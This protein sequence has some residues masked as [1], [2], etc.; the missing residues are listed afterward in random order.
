MWLKM[1]EAVKSRE[2]EAIPPT[3]MSS[4]Y[5]FKEYIQHII[6]VGKAI[7]LIYTISKYDGILALKDFMESFVDEEFEVK[8]DKKEAE[9]FIATILAEDFEN[10]AVRIA[11][12]STANPALETMLAKHVV[13]EKLSY[14]LEK[15]LSINVNKLKLNIEGKARALNV[16]KYII[17]SCNAILK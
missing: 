17:A 14:T 10:L 3:S 11:A 13:S 1:Y 5:V 6:S 8:I 9:N 4:E 12:L 7:K 2:T 15:V 16:A